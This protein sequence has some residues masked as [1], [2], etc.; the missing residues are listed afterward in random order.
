VP[1]AP[2]RAGHMQ[3]WFHDETTPKPGVPARYRV[4]LVFVS[5]LLTYKEAVANKDEAAVKTVS[6]K[7]SKWSDPSSATRDVQFFVTGSAVTTGQVSV[8]IFARKWG[9]VVSSTFRV[10]PGEMIGGREL[11]QVRN[12]QG[13]TSKV[14]VDFSTGAIPLRLEFAKTLMRRGMQVKTA[15]MVYM[16]KDG[17]VRT[18]VKA[19]DESDD[20]RKKLA[21]EAKQA[22]GGEG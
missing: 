18:R 2:A 21:Q 8:T 13:G 19:L 12:P 5:P 1:A 15:E 7:F 9:Q 4:K 17:A 6:T 16:D 10:T 14:E 20:E 11:V 22:A 3:V